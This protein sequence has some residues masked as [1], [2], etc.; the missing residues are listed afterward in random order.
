MSYFIHS[1][2]C[3][4]RPL[5]HLLPSSTGRIT[6]QLGRDKD[7]SMRICA[8]LIFAL[9]ALPEPA[10]AAPPFLGF[11]PCCMQPRH[12]HGRYLVHRSYRPAKVDSA[13]PHA[14]GTEAH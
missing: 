6:V 14:S 11:S 8:S 10:F 1:L 4:P 5:A 12:G 13:K 3:P 2:K 7:T 9:L